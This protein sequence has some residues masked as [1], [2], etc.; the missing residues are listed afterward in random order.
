[1]AA[2]AARDAIGSGS[3]VHPLD[4]DLGLHRLAAAADG[5]AS[6]D[7]STLVTDKTRTARQSRLL[8][9]FASFYSFLCASLI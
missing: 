9:L 8:T 3:M 1:V 7:S 6:G 2:A 5:R 4:F